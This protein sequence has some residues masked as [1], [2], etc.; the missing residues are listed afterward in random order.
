MKLADAAA[1]DQRRRR[2]VRVEYIRAADLLPND[3]KAQVKAG[4]MLLLARASSRMRKRARRRRSRSIRRT[5]TRRSCSAMR[6]RASRISMAR[7]PSTRRRSRSIRRQDVRL[8]ATSAPFSSRRARKPRPRRRFRKAVD[9]GAEVGHGAHGARELPLVHG[10]GRRG[11][12]R[13]SRPRSRSIRRTSPPTA[14]SA[15]STCRRIGRPEAEPY[16]Q[17]IAPSG[18]HRRGARLSL[19]DYYIV[20][21]RYDDARKILQE[22]AQKDS[23]YAVATIRLAGGRR[24]AGRIAPTRRRNCARSF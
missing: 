7:S 3:V 14:R 18:E 22:V 13:R 11:R 1:Q 9:V 23:D 12:D 2:R 5:S 24:G 19:A 8:R 10:P 17:A 4:S 6:S 21:K 16:F 20:V 15:A